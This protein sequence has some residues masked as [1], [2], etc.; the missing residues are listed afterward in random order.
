MKKLFTS[1]LIAATP[2]VAHAEFMD[3]NELL[4]RMNSDNLV[5]KSIALGYVMGV[6]DLNNG[7]YFCPPSELRAGQIFEM[8]KMFLEQTPASRKF[9]AD[10]IISHILRSVFPCQQKSKDS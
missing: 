7:V 10:Q 9:T 2:F 6:A 3:G 5:D 4:K 8:T 1:F